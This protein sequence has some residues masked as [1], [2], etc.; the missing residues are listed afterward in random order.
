MHKNDHLGKYV[1][2]FFQQAKRLY[3]QC[4]VISV[5]LPLTD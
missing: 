3:K 4:T 2:V 1:R 5:K